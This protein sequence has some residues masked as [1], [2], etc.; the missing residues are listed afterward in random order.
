VEDSIRA[1][2]DAFALFLVGYF[3]VLNSS[4]LLFSGLAAVQFFRYFRRVGYAG[5]EDVF[6]NPKTPGVSILVAAYNEEA[7]VVDNVRAMLCLRYP[8]FEVVLVDDGSAD[9]TFAAL[10]DAFDLAE[11]PNMQ[12]S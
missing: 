5:H 4:Y 11:I 9:G 7:G 8:L 3:L 12:E 6:A 2:L 1:V 10:R